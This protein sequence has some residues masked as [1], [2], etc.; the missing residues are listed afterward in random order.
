VTGFKKLLAAS[1][2]TAAGGYEVDYSCRFNDGDSAKLEWAGGT[3]SD[4]DVGTISVWVKRGNLGLTNTRI[5]CHKGSATELELIITSSDK[6]LINGDAGSGTSST[7]TLVL[8]DPLAWYHIVTT[9]DTNQ[10]TAADRIKVYVNNVQ[11]TAWDGTP[12]LYI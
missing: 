1:G 6:L 3:V 7:S 9:V 8:R 5:W 4:A 12:T 2:G 11:I 10:S